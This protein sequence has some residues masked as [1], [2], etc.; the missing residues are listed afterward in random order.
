M[1]EN[2][3]SNQKEKE[4]ELS[5]V[6]AVIHTRWLQKLQEYRE[7]GETSKKEGYQI[8]SNSGNLFAEAL[9]WRSFPLQHLAFEFAASCSFPV[10]MY[11]FETKDSGKRRFLV[12]NDQFWFRYFQIP[13]RDRHFY[14]L[15]RENT[16]CHLYLD[17]EFFTAYNP[18]LDG[19]AL[20]HALLEALCARIESH[21]KVQC[22]SNHAIML[23]SSTES[24][25]SR[26]V[27]LRIPNTCFRNNKHVGNFVTA[28][29]Y[30][31][32]SNWYCSKAHI[33][34][35]DTVHEC[36][37]PAVYQTSRP[38]LDLKV[39]NE[40]GQR[41]WFVDLGVY[42][43]NR[44]F[45]IYMSSKHNKTAVLTRAVDCPGNIVSKQGERYHREV[46]EK[47]LVS[48][49]KFNEQTRI[50]TYRDHAR[51]P[52][53]ASKGHSQGPKAPKH[54]SQPGSNFTNP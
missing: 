49:V 2:E 25:F 6:T 36:K 28:T 45:R 51:S 30:D 15:I 26:H 38:H 13:Q 50:L 31:I 11:A 32:Q 53:K 48:N 37:T 46:F 19:A 42:T 21:F 54:T 40:Y 10:C 43:R 33:E 12:S 20:S 24:K 34:D 35:N 39:N 27:T 44:T 4:R 47:T 18:C 16:P 29:V 1:G 17:L 52:F 8:I 7:A 5:S 9:V 22:T 23:D 3:S 41:V 14:E